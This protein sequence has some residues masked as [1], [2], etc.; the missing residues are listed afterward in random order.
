MNYQILLSE[1]N[2]MKQVKNHFNSFSQPLL[3]KLLSD[4]KKQMAI[5]EECIVQCHRKTGAPAPLLSDCFSTHGGA[6]TLNIE[7]LLDTDKIPVNFSVRKTKENNLTL[8]VNTCDTLGFFE[9]KAHVPADISSCNFSLV[10]EF[11]GNRIILKYNSLRQ[12]YQMS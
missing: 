8:E 10:Y 11:I 6:T 3:S 4:M 9:F 1:L 12:L 5:P 7:I 2:S